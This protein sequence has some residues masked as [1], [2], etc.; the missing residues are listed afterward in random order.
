MWEYVYI[1]TYIYIYIV[2][3]TNVDINI[4]IHIYTA[5]NINTDVDQHWHLHHLCIHWYVHQCWHWRWH[6]HVHLHMHL[7]S[8]YTPKQLLLIF[9]PWTPW[10]GALLQTRLA[11]L[12]H[13]GAAR[14]AV[15]SP[16]GS[17]H[18][19]PSCL[20]T[21]ALP[22]FN[23]WGWNFP[24]CTSVSPQTFRGWVSLSWRWDR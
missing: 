8:F 19:P 16:G 21:T 3:N 14:A 4:D 1:N 15:G 18:S 20:S 12:S 10:V 5:I 13:A 7:L 9:P 22:G 2:I 11:G 17:H 23:H 6:L 24:F